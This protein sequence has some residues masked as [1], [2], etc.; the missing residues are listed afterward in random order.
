MLQCETARTM[1]SHTMND[2]RFM[3]RPHRSQMVAFVTPY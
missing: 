1:F 3:L 2:A